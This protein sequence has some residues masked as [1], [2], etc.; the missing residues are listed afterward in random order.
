MSAERARGRADLER[1]D[2]PIFPACVELAIRF[3]HAHR[4]ECLAFLRSGIGRGDVVGDGHELAQASD[5][6][7]TRMTPK[8][9][10]GEHMGEERHDEVVDEVEKRAKL[11]YEELRHH[12][13]K[14]WDETIVPHQR[15]YLTLAR[16]MIAQENA[17]D[18]KLRQLDEALSQLEERKSELA[19]AKENA[20]NLKNEMLLIL[21]EK[22]HAEATEK[23]LSE[24]I[25]TYRRMH[26]KL[27]ET[28]Y[29]LSQRLP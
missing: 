14:R 9:E 25:A 4:D 24:I 11:L 12:A 15:P 6:V 20:S 19:L 17:F 26:E 21:E 5:V 28:I 16:D 18:V 10:T 1:P 8:K 22:Q 7:E 2:A 3:M 13:A 23:S 27:V 29:I